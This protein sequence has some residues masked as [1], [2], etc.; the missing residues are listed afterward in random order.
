MRKRE[1]EL[2]KA[3]GMTRRSGKERRKKIIKGGG[4]MRRSCRKKIDTFTQVKAHYSFAS[5]FVGK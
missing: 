2:A 1:E 4:N 5:E 3:N